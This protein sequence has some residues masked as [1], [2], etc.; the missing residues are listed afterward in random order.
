MAEKAV[1]KNKTRSDKADVQKPAKSVTAVA[2]KQQ[3]R[4][5]AR[6]L[7]LSPRKMRLVTNL[8]KNMRVADA[9]TQLQFTNKKGAK[10]VT[11]LLMSAVANAE[12]NFSLNRE[13][14]FIKTITCDMGTVL[15]RSFPRARGSASIIRRKMSHVNVVLEERAYK[16]KKIKS[17]VP[18]PAAKERTAKKSSPEA[19]TAEIPKDKQVKETHP[20]NDRTLVEQKTSP[21]NQIK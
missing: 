14:L 5:H 20:E 15:K 7:R 13:G 11:K 6:N 10:M 9:L 17:V 2:D 19:I 4:A 21:E 12:H 1:Q 18:K 3:V 8:V 16:A